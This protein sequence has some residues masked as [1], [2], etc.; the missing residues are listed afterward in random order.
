MGMKTFVDVF[1]PADGEKCSVIVQRL[2]E[3]GLNPALGTH[4]FVYEWEDP[5]PTISQVCE[6]VDA[7]Q[8]RL[9][10]TGAVLRFT[11]QRE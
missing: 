3:M 11:S 2:L 10:G 8:E 4:D 6:M 1:I 7:A 5:I 9:S